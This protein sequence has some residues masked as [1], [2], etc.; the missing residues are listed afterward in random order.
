MS[1]TARYTALCSRCGQR[2]AVNRVGGIHEHEARIRGDGPCPGGGEPP[3]EH[4]ERCSACRALVGYGAQ[5]V[6][7]CRNPPMP[8]LSR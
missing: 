2:R 8:V 5:H 7:D 3:S 4:T 1:A 6:A